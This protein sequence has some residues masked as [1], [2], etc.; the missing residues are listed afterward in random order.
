MSRKLYGFHIHRTEITRILLIY[1]IFTGAS[2]AVKLLNFATRIFFPIVFHFNWLVYRQDICTA[3]VITHNHIHIQ[4]NYIC[5]S[6][7]SPMA[8]QIMANVCVTLIRIIFEGENYCRK[9][10]AQVYANRPTKKKSG[11]KLAFFRF[12][13]IPPFQSQCVAKLPYEILDEICCRWHFQIDLKKNVP[14][15]H[16]NLS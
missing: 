8:T 16:D 11:W 14:H 3:S 7:T 6:T 15:F 9:T 13:A 4:D 1:C 10:T 5:K 12:D 2:S